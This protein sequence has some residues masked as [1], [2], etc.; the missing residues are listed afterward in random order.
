MITCISKV[1]ADI[2]SP[3]TGVPAVAQW[4]KNPTA[5]A[6]VAMEAQ[7]LTARWLKDPE[8][9]QLQPRSQL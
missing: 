3:T 9:L 2:K 5:A 7:V 4:V 1:E 8:L 6:W